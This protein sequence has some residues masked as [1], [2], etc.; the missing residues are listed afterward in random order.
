[1]ALITSNLAVLT[2]NSEVAVC[3]KSSTFQADLDLKDLQCSASNGTK[4]FAP[5]NY[6]WSGSGTFNYDTAAGLSLND[7]LAALKS[8]TTKTFS[9]AYTGGVTITGNVWI[10][11][12][13]SNNPEN[14]EVVEIS[15]TYTGDD[16]FTVA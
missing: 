1:M 12:V 13:T 15:Y 11:N 8:R 2:I 7:L 5:G 4:R 10:T 3:P 9:L 16:D 14:S 6:G